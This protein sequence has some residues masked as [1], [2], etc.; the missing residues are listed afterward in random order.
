VVSLPDGA[1][2]LSDPL[3]VLSVGQALAQAMSSARAERR[4]PAE[5]SYAPLLTIQSGRRGA[6][7]FFC[8]PGAGANLIDFVPLASAL[9]DE[10]P[11]H[12]F[13]LRGMD[14]AL[15]PYSTVEAA[16]QAYLRALDRIKPQGGLH[17]VG[18]SFGGWIAFEMALRLQARDWAVLSLTLLDSEVPGGGGRVGQEYTRAEALM[19]LVSLF[20]EAAQ[21]PLGLR[22]SDFEGLSIDAQLRL[23]HRHLV[24]VGLMPARSSAEMLR[25]TVRSFGTALRTQYSPQGTYSG[26]TRLVLAR[27]VGE[28]VDGREQHLQKNIAGWC[29]W[30]PN[31]T[32]RQETGNHVT[33]LKQPHIASVANWML[34]GISAPDKSI[35]R[36]GH[37]TVSWWDRGYATRGV[38]Q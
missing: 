35:R 6:A 11:V 34:D 19:E 27:S 14:G 16:A 25:G 33:L 7:P 8:V 38:S 36:E 12:G 30:A 31:L 29:R 17:L 15:L 22:L 13:Q 1:E 9:G 21:K 3:R 20:E 26:V 28:L 4:V 37:F 23:L 5:R 10:H 2:A 24:P 32:Y 18:H